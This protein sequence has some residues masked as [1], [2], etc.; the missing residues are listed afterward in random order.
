MG[1]SVEMTLTIY[2]NGSIITRWPSCPYMKKQKQKKKKKKNHLRYLLWNH[3]SFEAESLYM[4]S[5]TQG[6]PSLF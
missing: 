4:A 2:S 3:E 1:P 6:L 5:G